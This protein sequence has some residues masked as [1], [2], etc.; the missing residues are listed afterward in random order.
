MGEVIKFPDGEFAILT[1]E[2]CDLDLVREHVMHFLLDYRLA[3]EQAFN[4]GRQGGLPMKEISE[5]DFCVASE[6]ADRIIEF[7]EDRL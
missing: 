7:M 5:F 4:A 6:F 2:A 1:E 3:A